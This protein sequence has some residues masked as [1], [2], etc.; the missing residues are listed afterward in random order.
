M[1]WK[2][3]HACVGQLLGEVLDE[4]RSTRRVEHPADVRLLQQQQLGVAGD[5]PRETRCGTREAAG[6]RDVERMH[7]HGVGTTD[8]CRERRQRGAQ[9]VHPRIALRHHRQRRDRVHGRGA[10]VGLPDHLGD[11]RPQLARRTQFRDRHELVVVGGEAESDLPQRVRYPRCRRRR[12]S[13]DRPPPAATLPANSHDALAPRWWKAGPSTV[14]ARTPPSYA[15]DLGRH[16]DD[17]GQLGGGP[18][19][20]RR[21]QRVGAQ[22]KRQPG[23]LVVVQIGHQ[24]QHRIGGGHV[25]GAR[26]VKDHRHQIKEH[27]LE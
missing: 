17:V 10:R 21:G 15:V 27:A 26:D 1:S 16:R 12:A 7:Q 9:H 13:A 22:I 8:A 11:P 6:N 14:I 20:Q 18:P 24:R 3:F 4:P 25:V 5:A 19:A 2:C 23:A